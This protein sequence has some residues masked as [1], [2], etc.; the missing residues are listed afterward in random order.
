MKSVPSLPEI[1]REAGEIPGVGAGPF[2][3]RECVG[4]DHPQNEVAAQAH[5]VTDLLE[6]ASA[7]P[8]L[9]AHL[10]GRQGREWGDGIV[11]AVRAWKKKKK[12]QL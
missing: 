6:E 3:V 7:A 1:E 10:R 8:A 12:S 9:A 2:A 4:A 11:R 5:A